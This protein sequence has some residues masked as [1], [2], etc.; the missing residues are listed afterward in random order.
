MVRPQKWV[1]SGTVGE[2]VEVRRDGLAAAHRDQLLVAERTLLA[3]EGAAATVEEGRVGDVHRVVRADAGG[4]DAGALRRTG[5]AGAG[6][7]SPAG[8]SVGLASVGG[9]FSCGIRVSPSK[10][11]TSSSW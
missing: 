6:G 3:L 11:L 9:K 8:V 7:A 2:Q 5:S 1:G 4:D 10:T